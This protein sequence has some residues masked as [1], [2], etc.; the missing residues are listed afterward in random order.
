VIPAFAGG[1]DGRP[2][3]S[4]YF[5]GGRIDALVSLTGFSLIGGPA[6]NDSAPRW[7]C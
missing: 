2:A 6:Y 5:E 4:T 1:L 3:I 7:R